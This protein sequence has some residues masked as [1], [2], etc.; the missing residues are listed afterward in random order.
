[1]ETAADER[2][3]LGR[4]GQNLRSGA[5]STDCC[6]GIHQIKV[7]TAVEFALLCSRW[8]SGGLYTSELINGYEVFYEILI[9]HG[10]ATKAEKAFQ[11]KVA[12]VDAKFRLFTCEWAF[13]RVYAN[14][15]RVNHARRSGLSAA[16]HAEDARLFSRIAGQSNAV[17]RGG[18]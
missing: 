6:D 13:P 10:N 4:E 8:L 16:A 9:N 18:D 15:M 1:V 12:S 7:L 2:P 17:H 3:N 5:F 14:V 11:E